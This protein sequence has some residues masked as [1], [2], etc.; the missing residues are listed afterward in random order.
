MFDRKNKST[1]PTTSASPQQAN[2]LARSAAQSPTSTPLVSISL[3]PDIISYI[4]NHPGLIADALINGSFL[5]TYPNLNLPMAPMNITVA[6]LKPLLDQLD[7]DKLG[8]IQRAV[9][10]RTPFF[11]LIAKA[12]GADYVF[13]LQQRMGN[14]KPGNLTETQLTADAFIEQ[15]AERA[16]Y[17]NA[18]DLDQTNKDIDPK[19]GRPASNFQGKNLLGFFGFTS[20]LPLF[21]QWG[22]QMRVFTPD[23]KAEA[24]V[25]ARRNT[26]NLTVPVIVFRG[27]EGVQ[28]NATEGGVDTIV[29]DAA[30]ASVG[31]EQ[32]KMN[33]ELINGALNR[34][35][36]GIFAGHSLG[37][38]LAQV[39]AAQHPDKVT[40]VVTFQSPG[41]PAGLAAQFARANQSQAHHYRV[42]GDIVPK[43]GQAMLPGQINY[44]TRF[45]K[46]KDAS[47]FKADLGM[48]S[49]H[50]SFPLTTVLQGQDPKTLSPEQQAILQFGAHDRSEVQEG[51]QARMA[52]EGTFDTAHDPRAKIEWLRS[53][54]APA[55]LN[56]LQVTTNMAQANL[57]YNV[58]LE[59][60][61]PRLKAATTFEQFKAV[62]DWI[63]AV[64]ALPLSKEQEAFLRR[65][66]IKDRKPLSLPITLSKDPSAL[67][68][69]V[70]L[71]VGSP[72]LPFQ[73]TGLTFLGT[74]KA[75]GG[76]VP[77]EYAQMLALRN[78]IG[79]HWSAQHGGQPLP[80]GWL[81]RVSK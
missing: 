68:T 28:L 80:M 7:A 40:R 49:T 34:V 57:G 61:Q 31:V 81:Q 45:A 8:E 26:L 76:L 36:T 33:T 79:V 37:G 11:P 41:L 55:L 3:P 43:A 23:P 6:K 59:A 16:S 69:K 14:G 71:P 21:G 51:A 58:L 9:T 18:A 66:G 52:H 60:A 75:K 77:I 4:K 39:V 5:Y 64:K 27:T 13:A 20:E 74:I 15:L 22:F 19:T 73:P 32:V 67:V 50:V 46:G 54:V 42:N 70:E 63:S 44:F 56:T 35:K 78:V 53:A 1:T 38:G 72:L 25:V 29:G 10:N 12:Y 48:G 65:L 47:N 24:K 62:Y 30:K 17:M 2:A